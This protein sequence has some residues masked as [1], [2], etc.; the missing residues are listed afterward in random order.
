MASR[1]DPQNYN[2]GLSIRRPKQQ[3]SAL[4]RRWGHEG[5][6]ASYL[7]SVNVLQHIYGTWAEAG[8][9]PRAERRNKV[10]GDADVNL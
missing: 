6:L 4:S 1:P 3:S 5:D 9:G 10:T 8:S 7:S 2:F